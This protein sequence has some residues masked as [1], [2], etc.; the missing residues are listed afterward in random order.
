MTFEVTDPELL[1]YHIAP[2]SDGHWT[3]MTWPRSGA[4][5]I[6]SYRITENI[7]IDLEA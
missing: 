2:I 5:R 3:A 4:L 7:S 6:G 1:R